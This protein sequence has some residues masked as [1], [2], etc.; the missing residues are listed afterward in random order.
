MS[1]EVINDS[2]GNLV[3]IED[4]SIKYEREH[5]YTDEKGTPTHKV[6]KNSTDNMDH[7]YSIFNFKDNEWIPGINREKVFPYK[8]PKLIEG[9]K[10]GQIIFIVS[11]EKDADMIENLSDEFV[12]T[13]AMTSSKGKFKY[14]FSKYLQKSPIIIFKDD[15][16]YGEEFSEITKKNLNYGRKVGIC[17]ISKIKKV[18]CI[19]DENITDLSEVR[20]KL[21]DDERLIRLLKSVQGG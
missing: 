3:E 6:T 2:F 20:E 21:Q 8:L 19:E 13:T 11:G 12:V 10:R 14:D 4:N 17:P 9:A 15:S 16:E 1:K 18:L 5:I 7:K